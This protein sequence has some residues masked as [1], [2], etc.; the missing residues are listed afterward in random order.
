MNTW[1]VLPTVF[2]SRLKPI[3]TTSVLFF[4]NNAYFQDL[5]SDFPLG[6]SQLLQVILLSDPNLFAMVFTTQFQGKKKKGKF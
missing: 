3:L 6:S 1:Q 2:T 5:L 4:H